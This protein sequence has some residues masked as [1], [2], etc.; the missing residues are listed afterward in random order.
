MK[1][2]KK[3]N[4]RPRTHRETSSS[5]SSRTS[6]SAT[7]QRDQTHYSSTSKHSV[8][9]LDKP[10]GLSKPAFPV[11]VSYVSIQGGDD[12]NLELDAVGPDFQKKPF[13][14]SPTF[15]ETTNPNNPSNLRVERSRTTLG[16]SQKKSR[17]PNKM[18]LSKL[19]SS[20]VLNGAMEFPH[21]SS[22]E[23]GGRLDQHRGS[24]AHVNG[25]SPWLPKPN[26]PNQDYLEGP[27]VVSAT[28]DHYSSQSPRTGPDFA[29][30]PRD[31]FEQV[32][33]QPHHHRGKWYVHIFSKILSNLFQFSLFLLF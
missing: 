21:R 22:A 28:S 11:S 17:S 13:I 31:E 30:T 19:D 6:P 3:E 33:F 16:G 5:T 8:I 9:R 24:T 27:R 14:R 29:P 12:Q 4:V 23:F 15:Y 10:S 20:F 2:T 18:K 1:D 26:M 25:K 32:D 7:G